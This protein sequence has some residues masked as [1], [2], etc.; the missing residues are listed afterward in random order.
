MSGDTS[1][2][3]QIDERVLE[4]C[5]E[6]RNLLVCVDDRVRVYVGRYIFEGIVTD[7]SKLGITIRNPISETAIA[8]GK[9]AIITM[10]ERGRTYMDYM[11]V[12][13]KMRDMYRVQ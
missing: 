6:V 7:V 1:T 10:I 11:T 8:M 2:T 3:Q 12:L 5:V 13:R 9:I 4:R